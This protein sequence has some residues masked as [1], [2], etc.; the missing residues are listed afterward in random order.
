MREIGTLPDAFQ[1]RT[2]ADYLLTLR[3][4]ARVEQGTDGYALW[5]C[6]EDRVARARQ[7]LDAFRQN[8]RIRVMPVRRKL[9]RRSVRKRTRSRKTTTA[10]RRKCASLLTEPSK[11]PRGKLFTAALIAVAILAAIVT[12]LGEDAASATRGCRPCS[13]P[14][15]RRSRGRAKEP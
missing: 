13:S 5:V 11:A 4:E 3:I 2:L 12:R 8:P 9:P 15:L 6:D 7:E 10:G 1:A 14:L